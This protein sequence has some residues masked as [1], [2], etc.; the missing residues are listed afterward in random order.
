M[1]N[2]NHQRSKELFTE[3]VDLDEQQRDIRLQALRL[4]NAALAEEVASLLEY[5]TAQSLVVPQAAPKI[6]TRST[7]STSYTPRSLDWLKL[8]LKGLLA[9]LPFVLVA[10]VTALWVSGQLRIQ[11]RERLAQRL[12]ETVAGCDHEFASWESQQLQRVN[13]WA[14]DEII[15][16]SIGEL[17]REHDGKPEPE[18]AGIS[19]RIKKRLEELARQPVRFAIWDQRMLLV[20]DWTEF[21]TSQSLDE[22][23]SSDIERNIRSVL[24]GNCLLTLGN[25]WAGNQSASNSVTCAG[26]VVLVPIADPTTGNA[27]AVMMASGQWLQL[28]Y[29]NL[30]EG[31]STHT[32]GEVYLVSD[33]GILLTPSRYDTA[34]LPLAFKKQPCG[35]SVLLRDPGVNLLTGDRP[36]SSAMAWPDTLLVRQVESQNDGSYVD[37]YRN[38]VGEPVV[39]AWRWIDR[40]EVALAVEE[41]FNQAYSSLSLVNYGLI[42]ISAAFSCGLLAFAGA[43]SFQRSM[44]RKLRDVSEVG[45]YQVQELLGEGGMG[46]VYLAE[47]ALLCRQ[48]AVKVLVNTENDLSILAR[49]EREVQLASQLTH[50]NTIAIYDF[51]RNRDGMF[52]YAMEYIHGAHLGQLV[53]Y[54]GPLAPGRCIFILDQLCR[55]LREAHSA[56]VV[57]RDI[58]PQNI[59]VCNRGGEPDFVKL[60]DYGLVKAFAPG[61][62][63]H[64]SQTQIVVGTPRFMAPERLT[65]PWLADPRVDVYSV[66]ALAYFLLTGQLPPLVTSSDA[67]ENEQMGVETLDLPP[68]VVEFGGLLSVCMSVEPA[69]RPSSMNSLLRELEQLASQFPWTQNDSL[70]WW[71]Q[72]EPELLQMVQKNRKKLKKGGN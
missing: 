50:P 55:A 39:S 1:N 23:V 3:L 27:I 40:H 19:S 41:N 22:F 37:G 11:V 65:S 70:K 29:A 21:G 9:S 32:S 57:H 33:D 45:P 14:A 44:R 71:N 42:G 34:A 38:Y 12:N 36:T 4:Q 52:Y 10:A 13:R 58:K 16:A 43:V 24:Q 66:G 62:S 5:H 7:L 31:W 60:F 53:Q 63:H 8:P 2:D 67:M 28:D 46:R 25:Q 47:H 6:R 51:G 26:P 35:G 69:A 68:D 54:A 61:V 49:F 72:H 48:S 15:A 20:S 17:V 18:V 64:S 56:G 59:M 30:L